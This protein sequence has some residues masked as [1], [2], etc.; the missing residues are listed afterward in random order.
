M[1]LLKKAN[2]KIGMVEKKLRPGNYLSEIIEVK[3]APGFR[4][5]DAFLITYNLV[6]K[7]S[8]DEFTK[9]ETYINDRE[10]PRTDKLLTYLEENGVDVQEYIDFVGI[11]EEITLEYQVN[12]G[13]KFLNIGARTFV[14]KKV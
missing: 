9:K 14:E 10:N 8:S 3:D 13:T 11:H 7:S 2:K 4:V 6:D 5:G 12:N 1:S